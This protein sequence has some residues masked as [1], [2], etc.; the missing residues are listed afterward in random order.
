MECMIEATATRPFCRRR[1]QQ[2]Q[3]ATRLKKRDMLM[4]KAFLTLAAVIAGVFT[5]LICV[6]AVE[7]ICGTLYPPPPGFTGTHEEMCEYVASHPDWVLAIAA[8]LW[9]M[10]AFA[11]TWVAFKVGGHPAALVIEALLTA[12]LVFNLSMV[13]YVVWFKLAALLA[14]GLGIF[15][16]AWDSMKKAPPADSLPAD[17]A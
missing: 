2:A 8:V 3:G 4:P 13:P 5:A 7:L 14:V 17:G 11:S 10:T 16:F 9:G 1:R 6:V 12:A 15:P